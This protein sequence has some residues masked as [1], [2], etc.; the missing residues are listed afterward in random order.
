MVRLWWWDVQPNP[1]PPAKYH[2]VVVYTTLV[3]EA[4]NRCDLNLEQM[5]ITQHC[6]HIER[7]AVLNCA[8][9]VSKFMNSVIYNFFYY[10]FIHHIILI[11]NF[12]HHVILMYNFIHYKIL[13]NFLLYIKRY[14]IVEEGIRLILCPN[15]VSMLQLTSGRSFV[16]VAT[17]PGV[18]PALMC[19]QTFNNSQ[20]QIHKYIYKYT[21]T[22]TT[23]FD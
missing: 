19:T 21:N 17:P 12:L 4:I 2:T 7:W 20:I 16:S 1:R 23:C 5:L 9:V 18:A 3:R 6:T 8:R 22:F 14:C 15:S 13:I 10:N 11:Y